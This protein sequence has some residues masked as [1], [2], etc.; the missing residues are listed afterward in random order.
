MIDSTADARRA[1]RPSSFDPRRLLRPWR[2]LIEMLPPEPASLPL[3]Q[4]LNQMLLPRLDAT[5]RAGLALR[6]IEVHFTDLGIRCRVTLD[7]AGIEGF[8]PAA[9]DV[10]LAARL[11]AMS[12]DLWRLARGRTDVDTLIAQDALLILAE[13]TDAMLVRQALSALGTPGLRA[14]LPPTPRQVIGALRSA[15]IVARALLPGRR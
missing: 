15:S 11:S 4:A 7:A 14:L 3:A 10:P 2:G 9:R 1:A 5:T 12:D 8:S 13:P 6:V